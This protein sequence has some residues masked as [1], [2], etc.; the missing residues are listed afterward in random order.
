M[1]MISQG[2]SGIMLHVSDKNI[3]P[4][5]QI[6]RT[7]WGKFHV[8]RPKIPVCSNDQILPVFRFIS[9]ATIP[10]LM[11][12]HSQKTY[13]IIYQHISLNFLRKMSAGN[14]FQTR[15]WSNHVIFFNQLLTLMGRFP[16]SW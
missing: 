10:D 12:L 11:L 7:I 1:N 9:G 3:M 16:V 8:N 4:I 2:I 13:G 5:D 6:K 14:K 15:S